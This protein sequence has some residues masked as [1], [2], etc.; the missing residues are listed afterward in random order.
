MRVPFI[1]T[2][3]LTWLSLA[4]AATVTVQPG[5]TLTRLAVR[6]G[7]TVNALIQANPSLR[8][9]L[10]K[11]G[12]RLTLPGA[13]GSWTVRRGDTLSTVA[14]RQ[15]ITLAALL[16]ANRGLDPQAPLQVGQKLALPSTRSAARQPA[17][18][19]V[20]AAAIRVTAVMPVQGRLT[21]P[22][23][24]SHPSLDLAAPTGT[25]I[26]AA[27]P[28]VV[29]ESHFDSQ[30]GWGWTVLVDHGDGMTTRYS[31]NSANLARVGTRVEAGQVIARVGS[32]GNST[33]PHLDYR[34]TVQGTPVNPLSLY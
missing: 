7:T 6:H 11:A 12:A 21:T 14:Q 17:T 3:A 30:S 32:T 15:G 5:D 29:T 19:T 9:G 26:R 13:V 23:L 31:H 28:G 34:V 2:L 18:P 1:A 27:R 20:R 33:G 24:A 22:F 10:L 8:Q 16:S 4:A 25:P